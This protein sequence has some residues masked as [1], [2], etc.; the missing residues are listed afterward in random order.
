MIKHIWHICSDKDQSLWSSWVRTNLIKQ[1]SFWE[2]RRPGAHGLGVKLRNLV[3][4]KI[5]EEGESY[6]RRS[7]PSRSGVLGSLFAPGVTNK[8]EWYK[9]VWFNR[10]R[11]RHAVILRLVMRKNFLAL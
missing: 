3:S 10:M 8:V 5:K 11:P 6:G 2:L 1:R 7:Q 9:V 4:D